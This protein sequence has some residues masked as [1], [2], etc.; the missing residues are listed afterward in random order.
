MAHAAMLLRKRFPGPSERRDNGL[1]AASLLCRQQPRS[2]HAGIS[3]GLSTG[4]GQS[5][6]G[7]RLPAQKK[8][9]GAAVALPRGSHVPVASAAQPLWQRLL[10]GCALALWWGIG[11]AVC[12][13]AGL[14]NSWMHRQMHEG[15]L[16]FTNIKEVEREISFRT[17]TGLYYSYYKQMVRAPSFIAGLNALVRDNHTEHP[18]TINVLQRFNVYQEVALATLWR[19]VPVGLRRTIT[20]DGSRGGGGRPILF[21]LY[22]IYALH[23]LLVC[24]LVALGAA[25]AAA[26]APGAS[27]ARGRRS[28]S[29]W[30]WWPVGVVGALLYTVHRVDTTRVTHS[31]PLREHFALP[32]LW[33][34]IACITYFFRPAA[35]WKLQAVC[36]LGVFLFTLLFSICWQFNQFILLL[37]A[38]S[39]FATWSMNLV[40]TRKVVPVLVFHA[41][42]VLAVSAAQY[43]NTML[44]S[45]IHASFVPAALLVIYA[46]GEPTI[47]MQQSV[48]RRIIRPLLLV[49]V[50][51]VLTVLARLAVK[52]V[53]LGKADEHIYKFVLAKLNYSVSTDFDVQL[54][55]CNG[56]FAFLEVDFY[57]RMMRYGTL[58]LYAL[59]TAIGLL[60][61]LYA[62]LR[63]RVSSAARSPN[64]SSMTMCE[65][66]QYPELMFNLVQS[67][68]FACMAVFVMR[69]KYLWSAY[70]CVF[71]PVA[72][73]GD[74]TW[75][76]LSRLLRIPHWLAS[77]LRTLS[78][79][80]Y[81]AL[82]L[83]MHLPV[84]QSEL[85]HEREFWD[86]DTVELMEWIKNST[87]RKAAFAGSMQLMAGVK[88]CTGR[89]IVNH[90]HYEDEAFRART[91]E[92]YQ[93]YGRKPPHEVHSTMRKYQVSYVILEDSICLIPP[94]G[95]KTPDII[96]VAN[97]VIPR[98]NVRRDV[99]GLVQSTVPRF[100]EEVRHGRGNYSK[101]FKLVMVNKTFRV[102]SVVI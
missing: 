79:I 83:H 26:S 50:V 51:L 67:V 88:L 91:W 63:P 3:G 14:A 38:A 22:S 44:L 46:W 78:A 84:L 30:C 31:A 39:L 101:F 95:C 93:M 92:L 90:P 102:Y 62:T 34:Q 24:S 94:D 54:Y 59:F 40:P 48:V 52:T 57:T 56:A 85:Q 18:S 47:A 20:L 6:A 19:A 42:S 65:S 75:Q 89:P 66:Q 64:V 21:Y 17:E 87:T 23:A 98:A 33:A 99:T 28:A 49:A 37:Q 11:L 86:P 2:E 82:L 80:A 36:K 9:T 76:P 55:L 97:G 35:S 5:A 7:E 70:M 29:A 58:P 32:F 60:M 77:V 71:A 41:T 73:C 15:D 43:G 72:V 4:D 69:M 53:L 10:W 16:W 61:L 74:I 96:D 100:C 81:A 27:A 25:L 12:L 68:P 45:S 13:A 1:V 8:R